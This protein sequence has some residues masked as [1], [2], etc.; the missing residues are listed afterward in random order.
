M[1]RARR[2]A[3]GISLIV[4]SVVWAYGR[5]SYMHSIVA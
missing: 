5:F 1:N 3:L 2:S 4:V